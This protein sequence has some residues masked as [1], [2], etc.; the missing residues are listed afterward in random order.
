MS[1]CHSMK[2][3]R[4]CAI[5]LL[6]QHSDPEQRQRF[7]GKPLSFRSFSILGSSVTTR[8]VTPEQGVPIWRWNCWKER[9][10]PA[11]SAQTADRRRNPGAGA[12]RPVRPDSRPP[13]RDHPSGHKAGE[14]VLV[15][16][17]ACAHQAARFWDCAADHSKPTHPHWIDSGDA[18][19][20]VS[21]TA[22]G[23][24]REWTRDPIFSLGVV[25][26]ECLAGWSPFR[27]DHPMERSVEFCLMIHPSS[28]SETR[29]CQKHSVYSSM[30]CSRRNRD[31]VPKCRSGSHTSSKHIG[32]FRWRQNH[33]LAR[34]CGPD[35]PRAALAVD[36][37]FPADPDRSGARKTSILE[38]GELD[39]DA[40]GQ[41]AAAHSARREKLAD[42]TQILLLDGNA[43]AGEQAEQAA[44]CAIELHSHDPHTAIAICFGQTD[45]GQHHLDAQA[46]R[47]RR[48]HARCMAKAHGG[49]KRTKERS[50]APILV[51]E[52]LR[53]MLMSRFEFVEQDSAWELTPTERRDE[54]HVLGRCPLCWTRHRA[55]TACHCA[56]CLL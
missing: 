17:G 55:Y 53:R 37:H 10:L 13:S 50:S 33:R 16:G 42:G 18:G 52:S 14:F 5:K 44:L 51:D 12:N 6:S 24:Q 54:L 39:Q 35:P 1:F 29:I 31:T 38:A 25:L 36:D 3:R 47:A 20:Y 41:T 45:L 28:A 7:F 56:F 32:R 22:P 43:T 46:L 19:I 49:G 34:T 23:A 9:P 15:S 40:I 8:M 4:P 21:G 11:T 26:Y 30:K 27:S 48:R 2:R